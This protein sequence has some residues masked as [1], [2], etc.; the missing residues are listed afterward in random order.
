MD[1]SKKNK[2]FLLVGFHEIRFT[3]LNE[4]NEIKLNNYINEVYLILN[5]K[6][7]LTVDVSTI[8]G[9]NNFNDQFDNMS[10]FLINIKNDVFKDID[11]FDLAHM[12]INKFIINGKELLS[13]QN[14]KDYENIFLK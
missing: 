1:D 3:A 7:F 14:Y 12:I 11:G 5:Y 10:N 4:N 2:F 6:D 9:L 13:I 8:H